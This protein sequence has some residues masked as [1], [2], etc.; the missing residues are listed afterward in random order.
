LERAQNPLSCVEPGSNPLSEGD[1]K[2]GI[3]HKVYAQV[4]LTVYG[5]TRTT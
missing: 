5:D 4:H 2:F 1:V 3:L